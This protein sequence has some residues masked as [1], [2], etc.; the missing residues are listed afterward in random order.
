MKRRLSPLLF[1]FGNYPL[2]TS[3]ALPTADTMHCML[4]Y[5]LTNTSEHTAFP[6]MHAT[7]TIPA[8]FPA[9]HNALA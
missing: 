5:R 1:D 6:R 3:R 7:A 2:A 4:G 8:S 9:D